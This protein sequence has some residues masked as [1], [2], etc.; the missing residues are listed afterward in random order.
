MKETWRKLLWAL[1]GALIGS[2]V[3]LAVTNPIIRAVQAYKDKHRA[4]QA[5]LEQAREE[6][7]Q[8]A[9][10]T[11]SNA[12]SK[13]TSLLDQAA[14]LKAQALSG[15]SRTYSELAL[16]KYWRGA[17][18][19]DYPEKAESFALQAFRLAP[20]ASDTGIALAYAYDSTEALQPEESATHKKVLELLTNGIN[21]LDTQ[22][23]NWT[24][25]APEAKSFP[26][27]LRPR[28]IS[29][30]RILIDVGLHFAKLADDDRDLSKQQLYISR[31]QQFLTRAGEI[32]HDNSLVLFTQG[33]LSAIKGNLVEARD[34]YVK[35]L[36]R[37]PEFPRARNNLGYVYAAQ[38]DFK[39][40]SEQ[41]QS[42]VL[43]IT[44]PA[45]SRHRYLFNLGFA[46]LELGDPDA[47]RDWEQAFAL[48]GADT[49]DPWHFYMLAVH[50]Y[51]NGQ[52]AQASEHFRTA[53]QLG[54]KQ[55][56]DLKDVST[57]EK[58]QKAGPKE[59]QIDKDLIQMTK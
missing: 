5:I 35:A 8:L 37:E 36:E 34:Y 40:A 55:G 24:S 59:L 9:E 44:A 48:P 16:I 38:K 54:S 52:K 19:S 2:G 7:A 17:S 12:E 39:N 43:A 33:Y 18:R 1:I 11:L 58:K 32:N 47:S 45:R 23:L 13:Y 20:Q 6:R 21:N 31:A 25:G 3:T 49:D 56:I 50:D 51:I 15:L 28:D 42:A 22:Y 27:D 29:D 26:D 41:F 46:H 53:I 10:A 4:P 30:L 57:F 14:D